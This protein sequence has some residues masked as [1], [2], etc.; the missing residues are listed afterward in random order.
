MPKAL[1]SGRGTLF[2]NA[3]LETVLQKY[4]IQHRQKEYGVH[5]KDQTSGQIE[6]K[7]PALKRIL[8]RSVGNNRK[9]GP[10]S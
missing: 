9:E 5:Q 10:I 6:V 2:C 1:F 4:G 7:N 8:E 3:Q